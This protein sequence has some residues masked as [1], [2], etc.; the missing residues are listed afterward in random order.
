MVFRFCG[1]I[2]AVVLMG[3]AGAARAQSAELDRLH[4][5][6]HLT[7]EQEPAWR[8][9]TVAIARSPAAEA[10]HRAAGE[11][12]AGLPTP[13]R[14]DL[15]EAE[16]REDLAAMERQGEAVKAFYAQLTPTQQHA[17]DRETASQG[18][19]PEGGPR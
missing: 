7:S 11:M 6:L 8:A 18:A 10:R 19:P 16:M 4:D 2:A 12:M 5:A 3:L 15:I 14:I 17:F 9:Y 1:V 13:R